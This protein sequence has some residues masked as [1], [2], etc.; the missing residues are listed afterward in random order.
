MF[1]FVFYQEMPK[2]YLM[3]IYNVYEVYIGKQLKCMAFSVD[4]GKCM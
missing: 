1:F 4:I 2:I 3:Y